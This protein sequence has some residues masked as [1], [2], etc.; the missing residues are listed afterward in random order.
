MKMR[1]TDLWRWRKLSVIG[2][3]L[4]LMF[5]VVACNDDDADELEIFNN[6]R[7]FNDFGQR[8]F[9]NDWDLDGD[10]LNEDEFSNSFFETWDF[11]NDG[12]LEENEFNTAAVDFGLDNADWN[13]WD[14]DTDGVLEMEE[15]KTGF[16]SYGYY[17]M[18]D[19]DLN[20]LVAEREFTDGVFDLWD[21]DGDGMLEEVEYNEFTNRYFVR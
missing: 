19:A 15:F 13:T 17:D 21:I 3:C 12:I 5:G 20:G 11:D 7:F 16:M 10:G 9:F 6:E 8:G 18:F 14:L 2:L 4:F 1:G